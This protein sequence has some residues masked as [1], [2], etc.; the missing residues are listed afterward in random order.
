MTV[1]DKISW[2]NNL[3][4]NLQDAEFEFKQAKAK[5]EANAKEHGEEAA[6]ALC[7]FAAERIDAVKSLIDEAVFTTEANREFAEKRLAERDY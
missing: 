6:S 4:N 1:D 2:I 5:F 3:M 7:E